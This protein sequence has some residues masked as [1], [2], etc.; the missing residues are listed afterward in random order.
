MKKLFALVL[1]LAML[2]SMVACAK[3]DTEVGED[4]E[5]S[6]DKV[7]VIQGAAGEETYE[8]VIT[9]GNTVEITSYS[10]AYDLHPVVI[11]DT[12]DGRPV[13]AIGE[14]A[15]YHANNITEIKLPATVT[16]IGDWA[17]AGCNYLTSVTGSDAVTVIGKGAFAQCPVLTQIQLSSTLTEIGAYAF[18]ECAALASVTLPASLVTIGDAAFEASG[19]TAVS[20]PASV[21]TI[22]LLCFSECTA[23]KSAT[24]TAGTE[25]IGDFA[26]NGCAKDLV[27]SCPAGSAAAT[28]AAGAGIATK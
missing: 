28:Y 7:V 12:F 25:E 15:F 23:L 8:Y 2:V 6:G 19:L 13:T 26:F 11:P 17:F 14:S 20:I 10:G 3:D 18:K 21:K 9:A 4:L 22:G 24:L 16:S 27:I 5:E 1:A